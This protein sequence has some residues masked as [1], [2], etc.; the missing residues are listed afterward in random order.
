M[1][2]GFNTKA[3]RIAYNV[4]FN[5]IEN[6]SSN[7]LVRLHL[8]L[9][10]QI[11]DFN[12]PY[13]I[14]LEDLDESLAND[15]LIKPQYKQIELLT[16]VDNILN[17]YSDIVSTFDL[18]EDVVEQNYAKINKYTL[19]TAL[20]DLSINREIENRMNKPKLTKEEREDITNQ[21][22]DSF[23]KLIAKHT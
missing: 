19:I 23:L 10:E 21:L 2:I 22:Y 6:F 3:L 16:I 17:I 15:L 7:G 11:E 8:N 4:F 13:E 9:I 5:H 1:I 14:T 18:N 12:K 20:I